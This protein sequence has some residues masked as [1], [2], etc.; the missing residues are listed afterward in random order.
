MLDGDVVFQTD[1]QTVRATS[2]MFLN[3]P[4]GVRHAFRN[5]SQETARMLVIVAPAG[6]DQMLE[7]IGVPLP[8]AAGA[9]APAGP[10]EIDRF[11]AAAPKYGIQIGS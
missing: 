7:E 6:L 10:G 11:R 9:A 2:G 4:P 5:E 3:L 8:E 1:G